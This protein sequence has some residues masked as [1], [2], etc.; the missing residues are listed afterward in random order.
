MRFNVKH[1]II[2]LYADFYRTDT[3]KHYYKNNIEYGI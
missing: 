1:A 3:Y 2:D